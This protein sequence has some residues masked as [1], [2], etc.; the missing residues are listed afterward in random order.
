MTDI[1]IAKWGNSSTAIRLPKAV[2]DELGLKQGQKV[3]MTVKDGKGIIDAAFRKPEED[4]A[5][6]GS[7]RNEA[8]WSRKR[9]RDSRMGP[10]VGSERLYDDE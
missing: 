10:D 2:M 1:P 5:R 8:T 7:F 9:A 4:H 3:Q 6:S